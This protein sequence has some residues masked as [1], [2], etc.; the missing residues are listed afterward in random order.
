MM[1]F[2]K[3]SLFFFCCFFSLFTCAGNR[4]DKRVARLVKPYEAAMDY[5]TLHQD[6]SMTENVVFDFFQQTNLCKKNDIKQ[7]KLVI[8]KMYHIQKK[9]TSLEKKQKIAEIIEKLEKVTK[10][11]VE[12][13]TTYYAFI[14]YRDIVES[15]E[16]IDVT[17]DD[18]LLQVNAALAL[19]GKS[20]FKG[21]SL[22]QFVK[23]I[24]IDSTRLKELFGQVVLSDN[25]VLQINALKIKLDTLKTKIIATQEYRSQQRKTRLFK[26]IGVIFAFLVV[27]IATTINVIV[28]CVAPAQGLYINPAWTSWA[29][30]TVFAG[31]C[32]IVTASELRTSMKY[33]I[34]VKSHSLFSGFTPTFWP[35]TWIS[36]TE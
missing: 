18:V 14:V 21:R 27:A 30:F 23:Q 28:V 8:S 26:S 31:T 36:R 35:L 17:Q 34:P 6:E 22:Y 13:A 16:R 12:S 15:Y 3:R 33:N 10:F 19:R 2:F 29:F 4:L 32:C 5:V 25:L 7:I 20:V 24:D 1:N 11:I 9:E